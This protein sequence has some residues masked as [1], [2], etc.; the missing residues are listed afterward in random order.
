MFFRHA[1]Y[2]KDQRVIAVLK[3]RTMVHDH[4][5]VIDLVSIEERE[6]QGLLT[7]G[8]GD[9]RVTRVGRVLRRT[10]VDEIPQLVNVLRGDMALVGPRPLPPFMLDP[11]DALREVRCAVKP[12]LTGLW[13]I[14]GREENTSAWSMAEHDLEYLAT[15]SVTKDLAILV[16]TVPAV[17]R[18]DGAV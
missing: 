14:N 15:Q 10:S 4:A 7:K 12:G 5:A 18:G 11:Y 2:G 1:R 17:I 6:R 3:L 8:K 9:P 13:Q 16:K